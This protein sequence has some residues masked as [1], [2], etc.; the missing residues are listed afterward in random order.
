MH[1]KGSMTLQ[2]CFGVNLHAFPFLRLPQPSSPTLSARCTVLLPPGLRQPTRDTVARLLPKLF[3]L[4]LRAVFRR[5]SSSESKSRPD[6]R[7][8]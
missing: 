4:I 1:W 8:Q 3:G 5:A 7:R 2:I 6:P